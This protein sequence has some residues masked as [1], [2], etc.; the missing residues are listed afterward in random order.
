MKNL[1]QLCV[2]K[3]QVTIAVLLSVVLVGG[4]TWFRFVPVESNSA[5]LVAVSDNGEMNELSAQEFFAASPSSKNSTSTTLSKTDLISRQ[6]FSDFMALRDSDQAN[7]QNLAVLAD[8]YAAGIS[9]LDVAASEIGLV[10]THVVTDSNESILAYGRAVN[11][12]WSKY[13]AMVASQH[14]KGDIGEVGSPAFSE[15]MGAMSVLYNASANELRVLKVPQSLVSN[16]IKLVNNY[17]KNAAA[18]KNLSDIGSDPLRAYSALNTYSQN[19][20]EE[21]KLLINIQLAMSTSGAFYNG[22]I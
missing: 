4:A 20:E 9:S 10:D 6:L 13:G 18:V 8:K 14:Q 19:S 5:Q 2:M 1:V 3:T 16:H 22:G 17:L 7:S 11:T 21:E 12:I 15:F